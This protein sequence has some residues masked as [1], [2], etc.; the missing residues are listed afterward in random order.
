MLVEA[1][2]TT[3]LG[4]RLVKLSTAEALVLADQP[5]VPLFFYVRRFLV[6]PHIT[7]FEENP[8]GLNL[9]RWLGVRQ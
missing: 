9:S 5:V 8:R 7:G 6:K 2:A 3:D 1:N 4:R